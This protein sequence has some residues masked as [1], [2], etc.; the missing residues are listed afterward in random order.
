[1]ELADEI[2]LAIAKAWTHKNNITKPFDH[3]IVSAAT[4][5]ILK[6]IEQKLKERENNV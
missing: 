2:A 4:I 1:M 3:D 5:E 6:I